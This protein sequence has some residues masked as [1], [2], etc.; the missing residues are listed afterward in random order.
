MCFQRDGGEA[1][2]GCDGEDASGTDYCFHRAANYLFRMGNNGDP[3]ENFPL[4]A[5]D[6]DCDNDS[7][8]AEGLKCFSRN[9]D[10]VVPGCVGPGRSADDYCFDHTL[11]ETK[12]ANGQPC[13]RGSDC[14][15]GY[16]GGQ[17]ETVCIT[18]DIFCRK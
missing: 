8:C 1:V 6:G 4:G 11:T 9:A 7:E 17:D 13:S 14:T 15:S 3:V 16:C 12:I 10:E 18:T 5:C 2:P